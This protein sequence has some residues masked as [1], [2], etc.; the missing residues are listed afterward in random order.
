MTPPPHL[1]PWKNMMNMSPAS[2]QVLQNLMDEICL[3]PADEAE[4]WNRV[5][6]SGPPAD[7]YSAWSAAKNSVWASPCL[8]RKVNGVSSGHFD[9]IVRFTLPEKLP[10]MFPALDLTAS[11]L[12]RAALE[13]ASQAEIQELV[14]EASTFAEMRLLYLV[15]GTEQSSE[16]DSIRPYPQNL[17]DRLGL[18]LHRDQIQDGKCCVEI[19]YDRASLPS[20]ITLHVPSALDGID[21]DQF[22]PRTPCGGP[23][24]TTEPLTPNLGAGLPEA[25]HDGCNV[26]SFEVKLLIP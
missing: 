14:D 8:N 13:K 25:V 5:D 16:L 15:W 7:F 4:F 17:M 19:Q 2:A 23:Y 18:R 9:R 21:N 26:M 11:G 22:R 20:G 6:I 24:G 1:A 10:D 3:D 12:T